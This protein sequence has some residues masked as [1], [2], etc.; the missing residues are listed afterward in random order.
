MSEHASKISLTSL[1]S[2]RQKP[3]FPEQMK[4]NGKINGAKQH[5]SKLL[6][7]DIN[8]KEGT[9][10]FCSFCFLVA[11]E[12]VQS[13]FAHGMRFGKMPFSENHIILCA[14]GRT[15]LQPSSNH[16]PHSVVEIQS[17]CSAKR[18]K[19]SAA[20]A[21]RPLPPFKDRTV[22]LTASSSICTSQTQ[23]Q[24]TTEESI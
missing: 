22:S 17:I 18:R 19:D 3:D 12:R 10:R 5:G 20:L 2:S 14:L 16:L 7:K 13:I 23:I 6:N 15:P 4:W 9:A 21:G 11:F 8:Y 1:S 24:F